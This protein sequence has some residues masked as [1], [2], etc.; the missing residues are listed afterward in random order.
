V[1]AWGG[2]RC[3]L[4]PERAALTAPTRIRWQRLNTRDAVSGS[5]A[6]G[7]QSPGWHQRPSGGVLH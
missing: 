6:T 5:P 7:L 1:P 3:L 2:F 4:M